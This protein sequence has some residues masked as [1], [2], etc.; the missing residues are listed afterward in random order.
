MRRA[1]GSLFLAATVSLAAMPVRGDEAQAKAI[2]DKAIKA[3]GGQ[4]KL[5]KAEAATWKA[6]AKITIEGNDSEVSTEAT[7]QGLDHFHSV[8]EGDLGGNK[9][10]GESVLS[11]E[12]GWRKVG[13]QIL[14]MEPEQIKNEKRMVSLMVIPATILPLQKKEFKVETAVDETVAGKPAAALKVTGFDGKDFMLY[15][16]KE[17][18]LPVRL[19]AKVTGWMGEEYTQE[20]TLS[21]YKD[22]G[23]IQKATRLKIKRDGED[24]VDSQ[25][26]EF[27]VLDKVPADSFTEPK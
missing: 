27:K 10:K 23:G 25:I 9:V 7:V 5:S 22:F 12:K 21:D 11:G 2:L 13:G 16:D 8:F 14:E 24:F 15:F 17:S 18:G 6:K 19:V 26:T 4:E 20:T 3:L 1:T